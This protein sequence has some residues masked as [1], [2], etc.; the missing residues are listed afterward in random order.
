MNEIYPGMSVMDAQQSIGVLQSL[1]IAEGTTRVFVRS[2]DQVIGLTPQSLAVV[3]GVLQLNADAAVGQNTMA[4]D[5]IPLPAEG[6]ARASANA[7]VSDLAAGQELRVPVI[8]EE[9]VI[10][11]QQV[12]RGGV[13]VQTTINEHEEVVEVPLVHDEVGVER[14]PV[15]RVVDT[16]PE[17][18]TEGDTLIIPVL[19]ETLFVEKRLVLKEEIRVTRRFAETVEPTRV[20][21][22]EQQVNIGRID[23][24]PSGPNRSAATQASDA[25]DLDRGA[26]VAR[27]DPSTNV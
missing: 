2:N 21:L 13:R 9:A 25:L 23:E 11:K 26:D 20:V 15:G 24:A 12:E 7:Q 18:R 22:R 27:R 3:D 6:F 17:T 10:R 8:R 19:E 5:T 14:I 4:R 16:V 1:E